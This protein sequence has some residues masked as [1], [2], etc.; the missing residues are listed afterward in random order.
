MDPSLGPQDV[1]LKVVALIVG[2]SVLGGLTNFFSR[3]KNGT[4]RANWLIE[5]LGDVLY[6][7]SAGFCT[8][9]LAISAG[10]CEF[11]A[12]S[13]AIIAGHLGARLMFALQSA[14]TDRVLS[15]LES[16]SDKA[17]DNGG[18]Q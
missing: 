18:D 9:Y 10:A 13:F 7:L 8:W 11:C 12:A 5:L 4:L 16:R 15:W 14:M 6:S 1:P 2:L 17:R 3:L